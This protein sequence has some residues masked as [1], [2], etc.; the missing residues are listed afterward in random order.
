[1]KY[2][3]LIMLVVLAVVATGCSNTTVTPVANQTATVAS[4]QNTA[5]AS[6][7][8][9]TLTATGAGS[10]I[11]TN[12]TDLSYKQAGTLVE[13]S[14]KVGDEVE[15]GTVVARLQINLSAAE[16][17]EQR[18]AA[19][20][21][22]ML[23]QQALNALKANAEL[24]SAQ[25]LIRV[26]T[27]QQALDDTENNTLARVI[28]ARQ[29]VADAKLAVQDA[30]MQIYISQST[31]NS[32]ARYTAYAALLFKQ[33]A[34][35][36]ID[37]QISR[38]ENQIKSAKDKAQRD[39]LKHQ[40]LELDV[41]RAN[42]QLVVNQTQAKLDA[43]DDPLD[44]EET[45]LA[46]AQLATAEA[47]LADAERQLEDLVSGDQNDDPSSALLIAQAELND[48]QA[49]WEKLQDGLDPDAL[50]LAE[51]RLKTAEA[52]QDQLDQTQL[53]LDLVS[54][55]SG[56]VLDIN[57]AV[58]ERVEARQSVITVGDMEH[59][60]LEVFLD[61]SDLSLVQVG[62]PVEIVFDALP[63]KSVSGVV[64]QIDPALT[65]SWNTKSGRL[66]VQLEDIRK[67]GSAWLPVGLNATVDVIGGEATNVVIV[68]TEA[69]H[70]TA[71]GSYA[72]NLVQ[73]DGQVKLQPV[74]IGLMDATRVEIQG[75]LE[76]GQTVLLGDPGM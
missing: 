65:T 35:A 23:A 54:P 9:I 75:G 48:A 38:L 13:L 2:Q 50:V 51:A 7:G 32:D 27:A 33:K 24:E 67:L 8:S 29:S 30:E 4:E 61:E 59:P 18:T 70:E 74:T 41:R 36:E 58:G 42:Q 46:E 62:A 14:A 20:M 15:A 72:V 3:F 28:A 39:R 1:M 12:E 57:S 6:L 45:A 43:M 55:I 40:M 34:L 71:D 52:R 22:V 37:K 21:A 10:L 63:D 17:E 5:V 31:A 19:E 49:A 76:A 53:I 44:E 68:P 60:G 56:M 66:L 11:P 64:T 25:A 26:E 69:L 73:D 47:Q 16:L